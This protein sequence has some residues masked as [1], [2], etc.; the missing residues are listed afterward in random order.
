MTTRVLPP[1]VKAGPCAKQGSWK[2][3]RKCGCAVRCSELC[4]ILVG[5]TTE[6]VAK[7]LS[8][9]MHNGRAPTLRTCSP[10]STDLLER[11]FGLSVDQIDAAFPVNVTRRAARA[12]LNLVKERIAA[13]EGVLF[14]A[15]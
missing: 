7:S 14:Q 15:L 5:T 3:G 9:K 2:W 10:P 1:R 4:L 8:V 11:E 6:L 12:R 13:L